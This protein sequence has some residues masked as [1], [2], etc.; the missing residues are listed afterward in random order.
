VQRFAPQSRGKDG[1]DLCR[2]CADIDKTLEK[3]DLTMLQAALK[4]FNP[5]F[6]TLEELLDTL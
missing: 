3:A 5:A 2:F 4:E 6:T 1:K